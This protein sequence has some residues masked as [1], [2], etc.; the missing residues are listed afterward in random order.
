M[1]QCTVKMTMTLLTEMQTGHKRLLRRQHRRVGWILLITYSVCLM[2]R[3]YGQPATIQ[4]SPSLGELRSPPGAGRWITTMALG[5]AYELACFTPIGFG[6]AMLVRTR[7]RWLH[8]GVMSIPA[9]LVGGAIT[10]AGHMP[11]IIAIWNSAAVTDLAHPLLGCLFGQ[12]AGATWLHGWRARFWFLPKVAL[13]VMMMVLCM[14]IAAWLSLQDAPISF[15]AASPTPTETPPLADMMRDRSPQSLGNSRIRVFQL[16]ERDATILLSRFLSLDSPASEVA[17]RLDCD[18]MSFVL[19][20]PVSL[21]PGDPRYLNLD[22][23]GSAAIEDGTLR[24]RADHVRLGDLN[25]PQWLLPGLASYAASLLNR[26]QRTQSLVSPIREMKVEPGAIRVAYEPLGLSPKHR[27]RLPRSAIASEELLVATRVQV[28]HLLILFDTDPSLHLPPSFNLCLKTAFSLAHRRSAR[29]SAVTENQAALLALGILLGHP[30]IEDLLGVV[31]RD[32]DREAVWRIP[33]RIAL[34]GR[35][36]WARH[37]CVSAAMAILFD[38]DAGDAWG[39]L[40][41]EVDADAGGSGFS[42]ADLLVDR[43]GTVFAARATR[44]EDTARTI[45][46]RLLRGFDIEDV[47]PPAGDLPEGISKSDLRLRYGGVGGDGYRR[48]VEE[49][50]QHVAACAIYR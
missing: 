23:A 39:L 38:K 5:A 27:G 37:F 1:R 14:G 7:S 44:N 50:E 12:W 15:P 36:D 40:K 28:D 4:G 30:H 18:R 17:L 24:L 41:E 34:H 2:H 13:L 49:I 47:C 32:S 31:V 6:A 9:L 25:F 42:F 11:R 8:L 43:A 3:T 33:G 35:P 20:L 29:G 46:D 21:G 45:Q 19:S 10:F 16:T 26:D 22:A 48:L